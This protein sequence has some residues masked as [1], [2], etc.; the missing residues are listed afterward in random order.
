MSIRR[1]RD[2]SRRAVFPLIL[3]CMLVLGGCAGLGRAPLPEDAPP[4]VHRCATLFERLDAAVNAHDVRDDEAHLVAGHPW[5]RV[6]RFLATY[7]EE[8][9]GAGLDQWL[10]RMARLDE[11]A[12][13]H[14]LANLPDAARRELAESL[15]PGPGPVDLESCRDRLVAFDRS[16]PE[17]VA[18][19][20]EAARVPDAYIGWRRVVGLYPV[21]G[22]FILQGVADWQEAVKR[23]FAT[24]AD[25]SRPAS[26]VPG[27]D[28]P[29][30]PGT[31]E[32][33]QR[34]ADNPL[35]I[36]LPDTA[37]AETLFHRFAPVFFIGTGSGADRPG[38]PVL[39]A[40]GPGVAPEPVVYTRLSH[41]RYRGEALLQLNYLVWFDARPRT[42]AFDMLGGRLDGVYW[43][44]TL[45]PEGR[46]LL[47]D[48]M[49]ACG[50]YH[51]AFPS[52]RLEPRPPPDGLEEPLLVPR[53]APEG[54]GRMVLYLESRTHYLV[55]IGRDT[56]PR[57][58]TPYAFRD[59]HGLRSLPGGRGLFGEHG[60]V[61]GTD[62]REELFFWPTGVRAPGAMRQWGT[63]ATAFVGHRHFDDPGLIERFFHPRQPG[64]RQ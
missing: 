4:D 19:I 6:N 12:R 2:L 47:Y 60:I 5:L 9:R 28:A 17:R 20:R 52:D 36:P 34:A 61:P 11:R 44:V 21:S 56:P 33:L 15:V 39:R 51:M 40:G 27:H 25:L 22:W 45:G 30:S 49:H 42:G 43:R 31:R 48:S 38:V 16:R 29:A 57:G 54:P 8:V 46:P 3:V 37:A 59:Y 26:Y 64:E 58:A 53:R 24:P 35:G 50:C 63:H 23:R 32:I 55:G 13:A 10:E 7:R 41:A 62:R 18:A 14:E 1:S